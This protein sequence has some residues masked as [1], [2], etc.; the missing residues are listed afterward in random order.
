MDPPKEGP[1]ASHS[2]STIPN[3]LPPRRTTFARASSAPPPRCGRASES[4]DDRV[5]IF[6]LPELSIPR[7]A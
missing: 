2:T 3:R 1:V 4:D 6:K 5:V 7:A